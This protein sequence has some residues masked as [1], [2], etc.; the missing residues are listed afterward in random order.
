MFYTCLFATTG[1]DLRGA[2][3]SGATDD[4]LTALLAAAWT[5]REDRYSEQ[6]EALR[7]HE[8][9]LHKIEMHYIGG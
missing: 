3:R 5:A 7:R 6:R 1:S 8:Q 2:L 9:P 4:E